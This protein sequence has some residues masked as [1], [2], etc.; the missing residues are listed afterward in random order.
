[1]QAVEE[2]EA[3]QDERKVNFGAC[4][5]SYLISTKPLKYDYHLLVTAECGSSKS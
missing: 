5:L 4:I 3:L 1:M 2:L